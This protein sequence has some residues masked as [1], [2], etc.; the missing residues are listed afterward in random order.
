[1]GV[2]QG[3]LT[4]FSGDHILFLTNVF[5][6]G[7]RLSP[8]PPLSHEEFCPLHIDVKGVITTL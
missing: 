3:V 4:N 7:Q 1:M 6:I 5:G 8:Y 2:S